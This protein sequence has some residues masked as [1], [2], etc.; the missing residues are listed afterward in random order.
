MKE[1]I[2][3][4]TIK[5]WNILNFFKL[6]EKIGG[7]Y[8]L[9]IITTKDEFSREVLEKLNPKYIFLPH[10]SWIIPKEIYQRFETIVFHMTDLPYGR[11]G[12]PLQNLIQNKRYKTKISALKVDKELDSGDIYMKE[13][14]DVSRGSAQK[15]YQNLS[16]K[17]FFII[18]PYILEKRP[19]PK[20]QIGKI[21][22]FK[23]REP[24]H[25]DMNISKF[26]S[27]NDIYDF[28][29]MLDANSY[30]KAFIKI[31][32]FKIEFF[33]VKK[34]NKKLIGKFEVKIDE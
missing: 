26:V 11:G 25:S 29:R 5:E 23:R 3:I 2:V 19:I 34:K 20:K 15:I 27:L 7:E 32:N 31:D 1:T 22:T 30:P 16:D 12:S 14:F 10:W 13:D 18:I 24:K 9:H 6:K 33:A 17:I 21:T 4:A 28:I 8:N